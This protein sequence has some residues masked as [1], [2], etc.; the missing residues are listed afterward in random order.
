MDLPLVLAQPHDAVQAEMRAALG[1]RTLPIYQMV[2]YALG[3]VEA[4]GAPRSDAAGKGIRPALTTLAAQALDPSP[5]A[6]RRALP[7]AAA[8]EFVHNFSLVHDDVQDRDDQRHH[9]PTV[10]R[11]WGDAQAINVGDALRELAQIALNRATHAGAHP[12]TVLAATDTLNRCA[13]D[14]IEG[15]YLDLEYELRDDV[16]VDD[17]LTMVERKTGAML[18][19]SLALGALLATGDAHVAA[20][21]EQAGRRLGLAFQIRDDALGIWGDSAATGKSADNDIRRRKK[22]FPIVHAFAEAAADP[23]ARAA[24]ARVYQQDQVSDQDVHDVTRE[25]DALDTRAA[26]ERAADQHHQ[27]FLQALAACDL[28]APGRA[29]LEQAARFIVLRAY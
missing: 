8:V 9:R 2:R 16:S 17:Y 20:Q 11:Q 10:W 23:D 1:E 27:A 29:A 13:L 24:L 21:L 5:A 14:M 7:A 28:H 22:S 4:D 26:A 15:Q 25:L 3:W 6:Q 12:A 19:C 18:G